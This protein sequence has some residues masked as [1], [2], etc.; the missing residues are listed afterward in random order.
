MRTFSALLNEV[1]VCYWAL[2]FA[3]SF[4]NAFR[5]YWGNWIAMIRKNE[6]IEY[7]NE[8]DK[9]KFR[10]WKPWE[11]VTVYSFHDALF[12]FICSVA[13]FV[14]LVV[15]KELYDSLAST[16]SFDTAMSVLL[17]FA[18]LFGIIGVTGQ[19]PPLI[20]QGKFPYTK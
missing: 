1:H 13:G 16:Q 7:R 4:Y 19:L 8:K 15:A 3:L 20:Q 11:I 5:G 9:T 14:A 10:K 17:A 12:H 2:A 18:F 6:A